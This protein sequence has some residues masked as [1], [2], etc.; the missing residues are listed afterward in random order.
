MD[1][2]PGGI[3]KGVSLLNFFTISVAS[4]THKM[5]QLNGNY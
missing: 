4:N 1:A 2:S 5:G 3:P